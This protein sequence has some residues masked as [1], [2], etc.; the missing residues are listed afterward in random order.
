MVDF[1]A[2]LKESEQDAPVEPRELYGQLKKSSGYGYLRDV[3]AQVLTAWHKRRDEKDIVIKVNTGGGKTIDG[4][5]I[6]QS[7]LNAGEGP[8][9][10]VAPSKYLQTQVIAEAER[11]GIATTTN[12]DGAAYLRSEAIGVVNVHELVNGR[13]KFSAK[14]SAKRA[15]IGAVVIDDAHAALAT[16]R[17]KLTIPRGN[18]A[19]DK[20]LSLFEPDL[21]TQSIE[22]FLDVK[23]DRRGAP[24][25]VP[26]WAW[27]IK[28]EEARGVLREEATDGNE[29]FFDWPGVAD[30]LALARP[31]FANDKLTITPYCP[32][33][34][35][36]HSWR[37]PT[38][39]SSQ[40]RSPMTASWLPTSARTRKVW[41]IR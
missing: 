27:R 17:E 36:T 15:P 16:T 6:L 33:T 29:L 26:F 35:S 23:D 25:R 39:C 18:S 5:V 3:Q 32:P 11:I 41:W 12:V 37:H 14:R 1:A 19:F 4:L 20:L 8:S 13:T 24:V 40:R 31:V 21:R 7:Y 2:M 28:L 22:G 30:V 9:L 38:E 34:T 10:Y